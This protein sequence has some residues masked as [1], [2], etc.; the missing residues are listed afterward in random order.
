MTDDVAS[1][2][3]VI[4]RPMLIA[5]GVRDATATTWLYPLQAAAAEFEITT[6]LRVV[7]WIANVAH[8]SA[9]LSRLVENLNYSAP[10]LLGL[11]PLTSRR[12]W[13][14]TADEAMA[15]AYKP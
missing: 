8:E 1:P 5:A 6:R 12:P 9:G 11:F 15:C 10:R 7:P 2:R 4:S 3:V 13:G 14:Y